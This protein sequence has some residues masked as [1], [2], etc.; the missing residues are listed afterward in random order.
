MDKQANKK[1][2]QTKYGRDN[3]NGYTAEHKIFPINVY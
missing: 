1:K 3:C 2:K